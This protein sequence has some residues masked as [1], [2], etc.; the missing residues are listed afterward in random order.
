VV[1]NRLSVEYPTTND[2]LSV[3][4]V[5]EKLARP[6]PKIA[7]AIPFI[8]GLFLIL[9]AVVLV[10]ACMNVANLMFVRATARLGEM[11]VRMALGANR[12]RIVRQMLT[13][14]IVLALL[15]AFSGILLGK[16]ASGVISSVDLGTKLP[17][18]L[19]FSLD[20]RVIAYSLAAA[21]VTGLIVG[22]WPA[23]RAARVGLS[24]S[25][26]DGGRGGSAGAGRLRVRSLLVVA[27]VA[28]SL[29]L[30]V[31]AAR[32][33]R[34]LGN[35]QHLSLGFDP[36]NVLNVMLDPRQVGYDQTRTNEFYREL[37]SRVRAMPGVQSTTQAFS[38]PMGNYNDGSQVYI[39]NRPLPPGE[40]PPLVFLNRVGPTYFE[41]MRTPLVRGRAFTD[42]DNATAPLVAIVNQA[43]ADRF[44]PNADA[45]GNR[46]SAKSASGPFI[47]VVGVAHDS[48]LFG[49]FSGPLP[50]YYLPVDQS[51]TSMRTLQI[52]S[53]IPP[54]SLM[55]G[56][57]AEIH[58]LDPEMP[59]SDLETM[60]EVMAGGNG[61]L[62]FR[63]GAILTA[64]MGVLGF[65]IA[66]VGVFGVVSFAAAQRTREIGVR[67]ALGATK[68]NILK[69]ILGQG[70]RLVFIGV[71]VGLLAAFGLTRAMATLLVG[72][73]ATD[74]ATSVP[75]T[76]LLVMV[77]VGAC[78]VPARN[79]M[80]VDPV[81]ALRYD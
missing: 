58:R 54:E 75:V 76:A 20:W 52:R 64:A 46:F 4:A 28:S 34:S 10:L 38:V 40:Q 61:F 74:V 56:V 3:T 37:E 18:R 79:A 66:V 16:W 13:E 25:L 73:H 50:Y 15:S 55:A 45:V 41:T 53:S 29:M 57:K 5:P 36:D 71:A 78:Y 44:W 72:V 81:V 63:L 80:R 9:A 27:Q 2:G 77:A 35:A 24:A 17:L 23:L 32:F 21:L 33:V 6:I 12:A 60:R 70:V 14:S 67:V 30:L 39:E 31:V 43:M 51:F 19:D 1:A 62:V 49:Y 11:A 8:A 7:S 47:Q 59:V 22:V 26:H 65:V 68:A 69:L 48:K 42:S